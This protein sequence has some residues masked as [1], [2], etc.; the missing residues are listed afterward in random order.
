MKI[1][2]K[3]V[4]ESPNLTVTELKTEDVIMVSGLIGAK[5]LLGYGVINFDLVEI[6]LN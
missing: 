3:K 4:Y 2:K 6:D 5:D 1:Y